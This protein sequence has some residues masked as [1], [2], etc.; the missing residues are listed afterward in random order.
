MRKLHKTKI[1]TFIIL[2]VFVLILSVNAKSVYM[3]ARIFIDS[4]SEFIELLK[5]HPDIIRR[6]DSF[7]DIIT[8]PDKLETMKAQGFRI[9]IIHE[10]MVAF[11][12]SRLDPTRDM[13]GYRTL[14]EIY[15]YIDGIVAS[16]PDIV[17]SKVDIGQTIEGRTIWAFKISDNPNIDEDE[18]EI[19][20]AAAI[21][22]REV[23]TPELLIN[24][25]DHL[26]DNYGIDSDITNLINSREIWFVLVVN[27][28]GYYYNQVIAP[29]GGGMWRKNRRNNGDGSMGIDLNRNFGY[30]WGCDDLG[31]SPDGTDETYRGTGPFSE[32]ELQNMRD[33]ALAHDFS[34]CVYWHSFSNLIVWPWDY[35]LTET[36]DE[37]IY[38]AL[39]DS[40]S[41][42]NGYTPQYIEPLYR[43]N[44]SS[45]DWHYG[46]QTL[47]NKS[48]SFLMEVGSDDDNFWPPLSRVPQLVSENLPVCIFL[49][50]MSSNVKAIFPPNTPE[51]ILPGTVETTAYQVQWTH[52]DPVNPAVNY[53]LVEYLMEINITDPGNSLLGYE[54]NNFVVS[55]TQYYSAP[56]S[57]YSGA[58]NNA[59]LYFQ[60]IEPFE[61]GSGEI[62]EFQTYY[63]IQERYDYAYVEISTDGIDFTPIEGN[64]TTNYNPNGLN[65]GNGITGSSFGW[66]SASFDLSAYEGQTIY[67]RFSYYTDGSITGDGIYF[68]DIYPAN[69]IIDDNI[70]SSSISNTYFNFTDKPAGIYY[71]KVRAQD[72]EDQWSE[73]CPLGRTVAV[74]PFICGDT[75]GDE[76]VN[77]LDIV[78][79]INYKYKEGA[80]PDP[81]ESGD[82]NSLVQPDGLINILD[83]VYLINYKYKEGPEPVCP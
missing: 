24:Y 7:V 33:F 2:S 14:D 72:A 70:V 11:N 78:Y 58:Q 19:L 56:S 21:H 77:I 82:V 62:L 74:S 38:R 53:E 83:I 6:Q 52:D 13:G 18:P 43:M 16:Y 68:D 71:Y 42:L 5:T 3:Q 75:N 49:T 36:P 30:Q 9:E 27:P 37:Y 15:T 50:E 60:S 46:E 17:S 4:E 80:A 20:H 31:S 12:Q 34:I 69:S 76:L 61:I 10:D 59:I 73:F 44:G 64:I 1:L 29:M 25:I 79:L 28:D 41:I 67:I 35:N 63:D 39:A 65:R 32:P 54:I 22:A 51:L 47:K 23:I 26:T 45:N 48:Y 66:I 40:I 81:M 55:E 8:F 57:F